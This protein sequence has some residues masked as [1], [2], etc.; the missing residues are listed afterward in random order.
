LNRMSILAG[1]PFAL[2]RRHHA[3]EHATLQ[4]LARAHPGRRLAGY[5]DARGF[6]VLGDIDIDQLGEAVAEAQQRLENG[7]KR[8][9]I[10]P[11]CGTNFA[12]SGMAAALVAWAAM[13]GGSFSLRSRLE[14]LPVVAALITLALILTRPLGPLVQE[15]I[16]TDADLRGLRAV[17]INRYK[18][19]SIP[20]HRVITRQF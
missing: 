9:A 19:G 8:L 20:L 3:L 13:L 10:H 2:T 4:V 16:T 1:S 6:W 12:V 5:S 18:R 14:R 17:Q 11:N 7:E 15:R